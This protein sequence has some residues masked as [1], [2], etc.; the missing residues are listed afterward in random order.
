MTVG[1]EAAAILAQTP[2]SGGVWGDVCFHVNDPSVRKYDAWIVYGELP[3]PETA[4]CPPRNTVL[5]LGEPPSVRRY[6]R[7]YVAQFGTVITCQDAIRH[8]DV[9]ISFPPLPWRVGQ[10]QAMRGH[11]SRAMSYDDLKATGIP[12]K[13]QLLSVVSSRKRITDGHCMR[14]NFVNALQKRMGKA[15]SAFGMGRAVIDDKWDALAPYKYTIAIENC[16][17]PHYWTEKIADA[18]LAG[19]LPFYHG[20]P[21]VAEYFPPGSFVPIDIGNVDGSIAV[22]ERTMR[23]GAWERALPAIDEARRLVLDRYNLFAVAADICG[24]LDSGPEQEIVIQ[25]PPKPPRRKFRKSLAKLLR[26]IRWGTG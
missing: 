16:V 17:H 2:A 3:G 24:G 25:P 6:D 26:R 18:F 9:R 13:S 15:L 4:V 21:N 20:C 12:Q 8:P 1:I 23:D 14:D 19:C 11:G 7:G 10:T 5:F 22:M